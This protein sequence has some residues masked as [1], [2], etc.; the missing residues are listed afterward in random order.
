MR[1]AILLFCG[2]FGRSA[3]LGSGLLQWC[4]VGPLVSKEGSGNFIR[5]FVKSTS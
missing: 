3:L 5:S 4:I 2:S 1:V